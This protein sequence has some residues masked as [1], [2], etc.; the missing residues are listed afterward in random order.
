MLLRKVAQRLFKGTQLF[1]QFDVDLEGGTRSLKG[2]SGSDRVDKILAASPPNLTSPSERPIHLRR[3]DPAL[4]SQ[5]RELL[6]ELGADELVIKIRVEWN[7]RMK[8]AAGRADFH[9]KLI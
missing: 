3:R 6:R 9:Q 8:S 5:T 4:E 1:F 7:P 2:Q